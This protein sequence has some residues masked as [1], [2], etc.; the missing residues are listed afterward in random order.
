MASTPFVRAGVIGHPVSHSLSPRIHSYWIKRYGLSGSYQAADIP[1]ESL[2]GMLSALIRRGWRGFNV[3]VP[4]KRAVMG[5]CAELDDTARRVGAVNTVVVDVRGKLHGSNTDLFGFREN[6][7]RGAPEFNPAS[8]P[9]VVLGAGGAA[10][11]V[12]ESL[13]DSGV[14]EIRL[15]NRTMTHANALAQTASFPSRVRVSSWEDRHA[16]LSGAA[17]L[18]NT[19]TLG[20]RGT[21]PLDLDLS[22]LP[23]EA[24]VNDI[25][26]AP[27]M[28][29]LLIRAQ[30][31]GHKIVTGLGMLIHQARPAFSA[32]FGTFPDV[33]EELCTE[34]LSVCGE[35]S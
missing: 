25:V 4:H 3:T 34:L 9:A 30:S 20:M 2:E 1:P 14:A 16:A 19:T 5:L 21:S 35:H 27:L 10:R 28:T 13:I 12:V 6:L 17:L 8:G 32:W 22:A 7:R 33:T 18:V 11:A 29:D 31:R 23:C 24:V 15:L 26:Y